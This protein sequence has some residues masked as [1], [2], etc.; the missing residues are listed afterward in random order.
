MKENELTETT[1]PRELAVD[2]KFHDFYDDLKKGKLI[3]GFKGYEMAHI[4]VIALSYGFHYKLKKPLSNKF[5][6]SITTSYVEKN[7]GWI[8]K[9]IAIKEYGLEIIADNAKIYQLAEQYANGGIERIKHLIETAD[10]PEEFGLKLESEL[11]KLKT[12]D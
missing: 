1:A 11:N 2:E 6:R 5:K 3:P 10:S 9:A 4:F 12:K 7:Y 8:V